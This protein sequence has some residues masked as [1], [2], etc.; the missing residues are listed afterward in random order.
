[1]NYPRKMSLIIHQI[2]PEDEDRLGVEYWM[3]KTPSDRLAEVY[4]LRRNYFIWLN[5]SYPEKMER[6]ITQKKL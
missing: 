4:R 1:M 2:N 6:V 3:S 5:G